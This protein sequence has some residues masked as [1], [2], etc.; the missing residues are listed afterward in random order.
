MKISIT[1]DILS[2]EEEEMIKIRIEDNDETPMDME[3]E[4]NDNIKVAIVPDKDPN[5]ITI[6]IVNPNEEKSVF[7]MQAR[8][9]L[10][11]DIVIFD[12]KDI[13]IVLQP[14]K[15]K[16]V[17]F[18]KNMMSEVVYGAE[19]R[20]ME[21]LRKMGII[22]YDSIQGGNVYGSLEGKIHESADLDAIKV[23]IYQIS[24]WLNTEKPY[25]E[26]DKA[27]DDMYQDHLLGKD[28]KD[29]TELG[30]VPHEEEKGSIDNFGVFSPYW[31]GRYTY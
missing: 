30:E 16:V 2:E 24:E 1:P 4:E 29:T 14:E 10:N 21:F 25:M 18:A 20:L 26:A 5:V 8:R 27:Y 23:T 31:S 19:S 17:A 12:H 22:E 13:D 7:H 9:A 15:K 28:S 11:G 6:E 3:E